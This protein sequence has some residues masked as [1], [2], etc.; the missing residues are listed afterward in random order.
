MMWLCD[1]PKPTY[2]DARTNLWSVIVCHCDEKN[3]DKKN[4]ID[5]HQN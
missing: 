2:V 4:Y 3:N 1:E 5:I